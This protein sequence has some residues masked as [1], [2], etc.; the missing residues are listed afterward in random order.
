MIF[1]KILF[2]W[3]TYLGIGEQLAQLLQVNQTLMIPKM[4]AISLQCPS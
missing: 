1:N 2:Q 3:A 4:S